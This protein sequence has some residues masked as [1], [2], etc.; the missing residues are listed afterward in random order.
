VAGRARSSRAT[1]PPHG[2]HFLASTRLA[3][4]LVRASGVRAGEL[5]VDIGAGRGILTAELAQ[6]G[7]RVV[8]LELDPGLAGLLRK[9]FAGDRRVEVVVAD[10]VHW[11]VPAEPFRVLANL[12]FHRTTAILRA[13]LD[14]PRVPLRRADVVVQWELAVK[15]SSV[16]PSTLA[17]V[18]W[19][20]WFE[21]SLARRLPRCLFAPP[22]EVDA[23]L[24][25]IVR[26]EP[27]L[28]PVEQAARFHAF[29]ARGFAAGPRRVVPPL[30]VKR[31]GREVGF[32]PDARARDLDARQWA[33]LYLASVRGPR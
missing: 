28:V 8:A 27:P 7:A 6:C 15:R 21:L 14:D 10:A 11:R 4:D 18:R 22:P 13:L 29:A 16:W 23:A 3:A 32:A 5:V 1:R 20:P 26:R 9:R 2:Q 19:G 17:A 30:I 24:L 25:R 12:P 31:L 33:A